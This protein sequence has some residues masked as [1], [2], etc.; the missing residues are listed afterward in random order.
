MRK[1]LSVAILV[2]CLF[3]PV[4][5]LDVAKLQ[6]VQTVA[7]YWQGEK[8]VLETD[9]GDKGYGDTAQEALENLKQTALTVIYL[10]TAEYLLVGDGAQQQAEQLRPSLHKTVKVGPYNGGDIAEEAAYWELHGKL[11]ELDEWRPYSKE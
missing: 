9:E 7:V 1:I 5:R 11:P 4:Q 6:P 3:A 10:D 8:I 2:A